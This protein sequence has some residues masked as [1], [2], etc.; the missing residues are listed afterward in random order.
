MG[1]G[2]VGSAAAAGLSKSG[3]DVLGLD[4][5]RGRVADYQQGRVHIIEPDLPEMI[6]SSLR[7]GKLRFLHNDDVSEE[8]GDLVLITTGT[9]P[10]VNGPRTSL[11]YGQLCAGSEIESA[12]AQSS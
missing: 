8:L 9:P 10:S 11:R 6:Q 12:P 5:D 1:L 3:H 4:V 2:Y 7:T